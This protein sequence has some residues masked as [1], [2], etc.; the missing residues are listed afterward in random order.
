[1][2]FPVDLTPVHK[3]GP[4]GQHAI[5]DLQCRKPFFANIHFQNPM[6]LRCGRASCLELGSH[7]DV[8]FEVEL[9]AKPALRMLG[10]GSDYPAVNQVGDFPAKVGLEIGKPKPL[11]VGSGLNGE[12]TVLRIRHVTQTQSALCQA[13]HVKLIP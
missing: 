12:L 11:G 2:I 8:G 4:K 5:E 10:G 13:V 1:L 3:T 6:T 9:G 7:A